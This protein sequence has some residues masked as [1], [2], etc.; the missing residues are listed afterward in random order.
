MTVPRTW[1]PGLLTGGAAADDTLLPVVLLSLLIV[2]LLVALMAVAVRFFFQPSGQR[3]LHGRYRLQGVIGRG[4]MATVYKA[5]DIQSRRPLALKIMEGNLLHDRDLARKFLQE[6][7]AVL[8]LN[9]KFP[10][11]PIVRVYEYGREHNSP[12]GRP[13]IA[14]EYLN[15]NTLLWHLE[16][17]GKLT[18]G[19]ARRIVQAV[20]TAL[21]VAHSQGIYHRD[22]APD[23]IIILNERG[24]NMVRLI[25]FGV[26]RHEYVSVGT[27]DGSIMGKPPYMSPEQC[28]GER[29]DG[30][31][32]IYSLG[33]VFYTLLRGKPPFISKN[34][35]E[36]MRKH[37]REPVPPLPPE[38]P[39]DV[40]G[41]VYR[42]LEKNP[43]TRYRNVEEVWTAINHLH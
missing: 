16:K 3:L 7:E 19:E 31:S 43:G 36:V 33:V 10:K 27:L 8:A 4:G 42:M 41:V 11:A 20:L 6:G 32:D 25:D 22:V 5:E 24:E 35:L 28:K 37:E 13:F 2:V 21:D 1:M 17:R 12:A 23:N 9:H 30:R 29:V 40:A 39:P 18:I 26:A 34:P 15:G 38:I 14:M